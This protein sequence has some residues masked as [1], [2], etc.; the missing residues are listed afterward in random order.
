MV[1]YF[2]GRVAALEDGMNIFTMMEVSIKNQETV[3]QR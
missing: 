3:G 1:H 2:E